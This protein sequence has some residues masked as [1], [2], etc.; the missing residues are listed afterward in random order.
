MNVREILED[1]REWARG[2]IWPF[3]A[4]VL[5]VL[6]WIEIGKLRDPAKWT[7]FYGISLAFH[8]MGH[9]LFGWAPQIIT[10]LMGSV[11]EAAIPIIVM[12]IFL[13]RPDYFGVA[14]GGFWLSYVLAELSVYIG[15]ARAQ[16]LPLVGFAAQEDLQH[17]WN[18]VLGKLHM[19][20]LDHFFA[21]LTRAAG[22]IIGIASCVYGV[23]LI[24]LMI[25]E[26]RAARSS[27]LR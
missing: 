25:R 22:A 27:L 4:I 6:T 3:Y 12:I 20:P 18:F 13:R 9:L 26:P 7:I 16:D 15:D 14:V 17:D 10:A 23:W 2:R 24:L 19:L 11:V 8:E 21:F 1:S 5:V